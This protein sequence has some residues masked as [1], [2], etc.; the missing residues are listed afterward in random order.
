MFYFYIIPAELVQGLYL[1]YKF[2]TIL[3][4]ALMKF[5]SIDFTSTRNRLDCATAKGTAE[6]CVLLSEKIPI[7]LSETEKERTY[8]Q[9]QEYFT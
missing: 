6:S 5:L 9:K 2:C 4:S 3:F 1:P 8:F 7:D